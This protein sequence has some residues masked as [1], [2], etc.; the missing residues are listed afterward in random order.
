MEGWTSGPTRR[1]SA[2]SGDAFT[3][4]LERSEAPHDEAH[5]IARQRRAQDLLLAFLRQQ[6]RF[7]EADVARGGDLF[8]VDER[9]AFG[10]H[11]KHHAVRELVLRRDVARGH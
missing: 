10:D 9:L 1:T 8:L 4:I 5:E 11:R 3:E 7:I 2:T 6:L